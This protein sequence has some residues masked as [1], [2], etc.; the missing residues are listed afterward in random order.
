M[1]PKDALK[2]F[3]LFFFAVFVTMYIQF[4]YV[5]NSLNAHLIVISSWWNK[6]GA[7]CGTVACFGISL[8]ANFQESP[9]ATVHFIGAM[10]AFGIGS[11]YFLIQV[12]SRFNLPGNK[13]INVFVFRREF[14]TPPYEVSARCWRSEINI[15]FI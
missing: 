15:Y 12:I 14:R 6:I 4:R 9:L 2:S 11:V 8:V 13:R 3:L 5:R 7:V 1:Y 10:M